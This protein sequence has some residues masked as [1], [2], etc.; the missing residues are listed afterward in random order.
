MK[1]QLLKFIN[2]INDTL[3]TIVF[4]SIII[5]SV[6]VA[7]SIQLKPS[8]NKS[9]L[10]VNNINNIFISTLNNSQD[11]YKVDYSDTTNQLSFNFT[12]KFNGTH[13]ITIPLGKINPEAINQ[14]STYRS[15]VSLPDVYKNDVNIFLIMNNNVYTLLS[16]G[17]FYQNSFTSFGNNT[18]DISIKFQAIKPI[19]YTISGDFLFYN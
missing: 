14:G 12:I 19:F 7:E 10:G 6:I 16:N 1:N 11:N 5:F 15:V 13:E 4:V 3:L 2:G 17:I 8:D 18:S 9:V